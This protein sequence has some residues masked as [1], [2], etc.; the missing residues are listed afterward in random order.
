[1]VGIDIGSKSIKIIELAKAGASWQ[2]KASGAVGYVGVS[3]DKAQDDKELEAISEVLKKIITQI[4]I[5]SK[6]VN[7]ALP[8]SLVFTRV[9]KFPLLSEE[10]VSAAVKWEA[11]QYIPIP[12]AEAVIQY[13]ILEKN[14]ATSQTSVL[15]VA[16]P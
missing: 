11:E 12:V 1:M 6:D 16:A 7:L 2:M 15:L 5:T 3:P 14:E 8:E 10:E 9:I 13:S 4:G